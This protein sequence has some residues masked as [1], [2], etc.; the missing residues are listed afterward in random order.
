[1]GDAGIQGSRTTHATIDRLAAL[2]C[3]TVVGACLVLPIRLAFAPQATR[4]TFGYIGDEHFYAQRIAPLLKGATASN[5][6]NGIADPRVASVFYLEDLCRLFL[7]ATGMDVVSFFWAWRFAFPV[8]FFAA[9][10]G[11]AYVC[12]PRR[13][14]PWSRGMWIAAGAAAMASLYGIYTLVALLKVEHWAPYPPVHGWINRI[15]TNCEYVLSA[16]L[17]ILYVRFLAEPNARRGAWLALGGVALIY[18]RPYTAVVWGPALAL[19]VV[20]LLVMRKLKPAVL[21]VLLGTLFVPLLPWIFNNAAN[22][23][24]DAWQEMLA[25]YYQLPAVGVRR[26]YEVHPQWLL[27]TGAGVLMIATA[28]LQRLPLFGVSLGVSLIACPFA[29]GLMLPAVELLTYDRFSSFYL[30]A[31]VGCA[32]LI[33][34]KQS[35]AWHGRRGA[36]LAGQWTMAFG[37]TALFGA[38]VITVEN[39]QLD[40]KNYPGSTYASIVADQAYL[41]AYAWVASKTAEDALFIVDDGYDWSKAPHDVPGWAKLQE[42]LMLREDLF[43]IVARRRRI[44]HC[45]MYGQPML[46]DDWDGLETLHVGVFGFPADTRKFVDAIKRFRPTHVLWKKTPPLAVSSEPA[47]IPRGELGNRLRSISRVVYSDEACEIWELQYQ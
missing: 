37:G 47:P 22:I 35:A 39:L 34:G 46:T 27:F 42:Q 29:V 36:A 10:L 20:A 14:R 13:R 8:I 31:I 21:L 19:G 2:A 23:K 3:A 12:L 18:L 26:P 17:A 6:V 16:L 1:M 40:F 24:I 44:F 38:A 25:R 5:P 28:R 9:L 11:L 4:Y 33:A 15:P 30:V 41:K 43:G 7:R 45:R 32:L